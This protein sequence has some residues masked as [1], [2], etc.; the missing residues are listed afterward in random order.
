LLAANTRLRGE[1]YYRLVPLARALDQKG[2]LL[3]ILCYRA[4]FLAILARAY[5]RRYANLLGVL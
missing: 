1:V 4:L 2:K 3:G 5:A